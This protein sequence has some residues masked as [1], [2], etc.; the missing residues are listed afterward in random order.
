MIDAIAMQI[1]PDRDQL[2]CSPL[3]A[4]RRLRLVTLALSSPRLVESDP[5]PPEEI[6]SMLLD[7]LRRR[8]GAAARTDPTTT[9]IGVPAC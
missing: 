3:E 6:V 9:S 2:R 7:G 8:A 1:V 5:L 4:A